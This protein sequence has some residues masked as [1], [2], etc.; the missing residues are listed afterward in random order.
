MF[1]QYA[2]SAKSSR[3][4]NLLSDKIEKS[5]VKGLVTTKKTIML[6]S[7][8]QLVTTV[9]QIQTCFYIEHII[10]CLYFIQYINNIK[11]KIFF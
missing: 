11:K 6:I 3:K 8:S 9:K 5:V 4:L 1:V 7:Q 2:Y 10:H